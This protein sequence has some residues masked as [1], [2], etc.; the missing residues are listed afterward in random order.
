MSHFWCIHEAQISS[1]KKGSEKVLRDR[2]TAGFG[3]F[4][5]FFQTRKRKCR[6]PPALS[7][8]CSK[9]W[10]LFISWLDAPSPGNTLWFQKIQFL[11]RHSSTDPLTS[12]W[13][14][15]VNCCNPCG[16]WHQGVQRV[17]D[18]KM[19]LFFFLMILCYGHGVLWVTTCECKTHTHTHL[20]YL[21]CFLSHS[22]LPFSP[23]M[24]FWKISMLIKMY[25]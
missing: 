6:I 11:R 2:L 20:Y 15:T 16:T 12:H 21:S 4:L 23:V 8:K 7:F 24:V 13:G 10:A 1:E 14:K 3:L 9:R 22:F 19:L 25:H 17:G 5:R 18:G